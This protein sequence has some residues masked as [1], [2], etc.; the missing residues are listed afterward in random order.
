ADHRK[1]AMREVDDAHQ[2]HG[3]RQA[4]RD[5]EKDHP[6]G[7]AIEQYREIGHRYRLP[8]PG[9][10]RQTLTP[11]SQSLLAK[12]VPPREIDAARADKP[13]SALSG[14]KKNDT[15][16]ADRR[17]RPGVGGGWTCFGRDGESRADR[18]V[19]GR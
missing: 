11:M 15:L 3:H 1:G 13:L 9:A 16:V 8:Y 18:A 2:P 14:G 19:L 6:I 12:L 4:N 7:G 10:A 17:R 5:D